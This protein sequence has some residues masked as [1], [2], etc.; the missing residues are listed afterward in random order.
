MYF[1]LQL[2]APLVDYRRDLT[3]VDFSENVKLVSKL[4]GN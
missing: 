4:S 1:S 3:P 2:Y